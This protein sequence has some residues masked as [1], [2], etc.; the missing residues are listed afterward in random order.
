MKWW[1]WV[2][3]YVLVVFP[4]VIVAQSLKPHEPKAVVKQEPVECVVLMQH[5][6]ETHAWKGYVQV[7]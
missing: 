3:M 7:K 4:M 2:F 1:H 5:Q 6:R